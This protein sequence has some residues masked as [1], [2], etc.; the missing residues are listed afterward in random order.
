MKRGTTATSR[1]RS[2]ILDG[3]NPLLTQAE[4]SAVRVVG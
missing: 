1:V 2:F 3:W 4:R